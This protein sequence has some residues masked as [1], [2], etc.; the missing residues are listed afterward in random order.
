MRRQFIRGAARTPSGPSSTPL[1]LIGRLMRLGSANWRHRSATDAHLP[2]ASD[3]AQVVPV[4]AMP[5]EQPEADWESASAQSATVSALPKAVLGVS[6]D[7]RR[8]M[9]R[10]V[11]QRAIEGPNR[12]MGGWGTDTWA[13]LGLLAE[14]R[15]ALLSKTAAC[16]KLWPEADCP[17]DRFAGL[18]KATRSK[19]CEAL[20]MPGNYGR[21][22]IQFV[23]GTGY[24]IN[25]DLY[26]CDVWQIRDLLAA[27]ARAAGPEKVAALIAATDLYTGPYL[28]D[29]PHSWAR[30]TADVLNRSIVQALAQLADLE[31]QPE[32]EIDYL[33]R[34]TDLDGV[35][36]HLFRR[37]ME[38]YAR[39]GR[40]QAV[41]YCY[42]ELTEQLRA[43]GRKP[44][45]QTER[46]YC[47]ITGAE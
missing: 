14:H 45:P 43:R 11:G 3:A 38:V 28:P 30:R 40:P 29:V 12:S 26:H 37:R 1:G 20:G 31:E 8:G 46:L 2:L 47:G 15:S 32:H 24:R 36:E 10:L 39:L 4:P 34:A 7:D 13:L 41:H 17:S 44:S 9:I 19:M 27:A 23:G 6:R 21:I 35:A 33:E 22:V 25:P 18:L 16:D 5:L 42:D